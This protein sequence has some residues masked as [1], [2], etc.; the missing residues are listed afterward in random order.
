[1]KKDVLFIWDDVYRNAFKSIKR[2]LANS[3]VLGA[4]VPGKPPILYIAIQ[5]GSIGALLAQENKDQK[6]RALYYLSRTLT[7]AELNYSPIEKICLALVF[8]V[9]S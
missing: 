1:M 5:E 6:E 9:Q 7:S 3:P 8:A 4:P 2:Y